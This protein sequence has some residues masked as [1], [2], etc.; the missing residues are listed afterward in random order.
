M[1][2]NVAKIWA[3]KK[4]FPN[5]V[6]FSFTDEWMEKLKKS[7]PWAASIIIHE[8]LKFNGPKAQLDLKQAEELELAGIMNEQNI[9]Y[10]QLMIRKWITDGLRLTDA[11]TD[12]ILDILNIAST[13][14]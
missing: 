14:R 13:A 5:V 1:V 6:W 2:Q 4:S 7:N 8:L 3:R 11:P 10:E 9:T 12:K